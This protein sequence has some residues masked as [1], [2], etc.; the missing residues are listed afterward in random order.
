LL[1]F[2]F[3][4]LVGKDGE[5]VYAYQFQHGVRRMLHSISE[6]VRYIIHPAFRA[7]LGCSDS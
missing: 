3:M 6:P 1:W 4:G 5:E 2:G 7:A